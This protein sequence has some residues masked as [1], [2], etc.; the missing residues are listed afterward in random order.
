M[1]SLIVFGPFSYTPGA[2]LLLFIS[3]FRK[4]LIFAGCELKS[5]CLASLLNL[6]MYAVSVS[7]S[8]CWI[9]MNLEVYACI[10]A[11]F[12]QL[13]SCSLMWGQGLSSC[14]FMRSHAS[15]LAFPFATITSFSSTR[16]AA[17]S[18]SASQSSS[19]CPYLPLY[20]SMSFRT[21]MGT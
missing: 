5:Q 21:D 1:A 12:R 8:F 3:L 15:P 20:V 7:E 11:L 13:Q 14:S 19:L 6:W 16:V 4:I 9:S 10:L 17:F 2:I 18:L